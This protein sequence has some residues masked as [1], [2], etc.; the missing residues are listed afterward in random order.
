V[1]R[2]LGRED[3]LPLRRRSP[4]LQRRLDRLGARAREEGPLDARRRAAQQLLGEQGGQHVHTELHRA[5]PLQLERLDKRVA[6]ARVVPPYVEHPETAEQV[7]VA[8]AVGVP[9]VRALGTGPAA[10]ET[11]RPQELH[12]LRV[13]RLRV[14]VERLGAPLLDELAQPAHAWIIATRR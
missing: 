9:E 10:V 6:H 7:E 8:V 11:N 2:V 1:E 14:Q 5:R 13:D 12:E 4:Q 3:A